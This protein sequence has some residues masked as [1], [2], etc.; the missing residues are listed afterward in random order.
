MRYPGGTPAS[1]AVHSG[2]PLWLRLLHFFNFFF[3]MFIIRAGI[4]I[5]ADHPRL[6]W[7]RDC[8]PGTEWFRF[9]RE[10]P[11]D[12]IWTSKDDSV[13]IPRWLG[14]PGVR[15]SIGLARWWHFS[16]DLLWVVNGAIFYV[17][18]FTTDQWQR[19]VPTSW[20]VFPNALSTALQ[21]LSLQFPVDHSWTN[22]NSLQQLA[23]FLTA[24]V[25]A[26][27]AVVTGLM[28]SPAIANRLG[29]FA[30][31]LNRQA[32]RTI[33]FG[34]LWWFLLFILIHVTLVFITGARQ[35]LN[36]MFGRRERQFLERRSDLWRGDGRGDR[37][38]VP[39]LTLH[40]QACQAGAEVGP[41]PDRPLDGGR[42]M[43][44]PGNPVH[45][46]RHL[47]RISGSTARCRT[48]MRSRRW[49]RAASRTTG[50]ASADWS[51]IRANSPTPNSRRYPSTSRL[52][53]I[54]AFRAGPASP[55]GAAFAMR[56][57]LDIVKPT[58][59]ARYAVFYSFSEGS[60]GGG[61]YDVHRIQNMRHRLD[62]SRL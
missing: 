46:T 49:W 7:R 22:Y 2:F 28:Q 39:R 60:E 48:P 31:I 14:I 33:H 6:Y 27:L 10:V 29:W 36:Y 20:A 1:Q 35:N 17:L 15:H 30:R 62:H 25:A 38:L 11:R 50:C 53:N 4:Q 8:T 47:A 57:I 41:N 40:D 26:P 23:Y 58:A 19:V 21:Y 51:N 42:G 54:S 18:L 3:L 5:L 59:D 32:A 52:P 44:R 34:V 16:F 61:Y 13:T 37:R 43:G 24:F 55:N 9:Q 45:G 12:R 56:D